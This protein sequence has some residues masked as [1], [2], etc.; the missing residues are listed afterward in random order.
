MNHNDVGNKV[1][2]NYNNLHSEKRK[3]KEEAMN[4]NDAGNQGCSKYIL[5][6]KKKKK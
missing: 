2:S 6:R 5:H 1:Y 4:H 3:K